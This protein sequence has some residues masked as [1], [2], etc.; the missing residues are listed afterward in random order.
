M[1]IV[2][3]EIREPRR[4]LPRALALGTLLVIA[5]YLLVNLVYL[6]TLSQGGLAATTTPA[7]DAVRRSS[8]RE[9][10]AGSPPRSPSRPS[11]SWT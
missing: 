6:M 5:V 2:A 3:E 1:N 8:A 11:A 10:T 9:R 4:T 7:A